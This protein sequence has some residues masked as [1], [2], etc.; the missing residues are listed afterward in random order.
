MRSGLRAI[1]LVSAFAAL[2]LFAFGQTATSSLHGTISDPKGAVVSGA[3]VT[4]TN[5]ATGFRRST[6]SDSQGSYQFLEMP[7]AKYDLLV[8]S[9]GFGPMKQNGIELLVA[10]PATL[11]I[12]MEVSGGIVTVEVT[13]TTPLVNTQDASLGHAFEASQ[14][15]DLPFEGR[16]PAGILSLQTGVVFT[17]NSTHIAGSADSRAGSVNGARSDQTNIT[18]DGVDNNDQLLGTAFQGAIRAPLD[19]LEELKVTTSNSDADSGRSSGGQVS[20]VT[21]SGTNHFHGSFYIYNRPT[22]AAANDWF[23]KAAQLGAGEPNEAPFLLRNTFGVNVGGPI[24]KDRLF[25]FAAYEGQRKR[26]NLQVTRVIPSAG[27]K[28]GSISYP[29]T[30]DP[31]CPASGVETLNAAQIATM[32]PVCST[33]TP[34]TCPLGPGPNPL[35][36]NIGGANPNALFTQYPNANTNTVGDG[37]DYVGYT[38]SSPLPTGLNAY[39]AK[40]DYNLTRDGNHRVFVRGIMNN[41]RQAE[42]N[43]STSITNDGGEQFPGSSEGQVEHDNNKGFTVGYTATFS[44]T[45]INNFRFGYSSELLNLA[46]LQTQPFVHFRGMDDINSFTPTINTHIPVKNIVDDVTKVMGSHTFQFGANYRQVDNLRESNAQNF[47]TAETNVFWTN[48]SGI[49]NTGSSLDPAA[50]NPATNQE[51]FPA[52]DPNFSASYDFAMA[53]LVG[54]IPQVTANYELTK[55]LSLIQQGQLVPR[56]FRDHEIEFYAQDQWRIKPNLT[57]TYGLR[58]SL[59]QP[60]YETTGTQVAPT[61]SFNNYFNQRSIAAY[62]GQVYDPTVGFALDGQANGKAPYWAWDYKDFAP[63]VAFAYSPKGDSGWGRRLWGGQGKTSIRAGYGI[64]FDHFGEGITNTFDRN[65]SFGLTTSEVNPAGI[66]SVDGSARYSGLFNIPTSSND[67]CA[68]PPCSLVGAPPTGPFPVVPPIGATT[69]GGFAITWGLDDKLKTPYSHV[70]DFS[71][72]RELPSNFVFEASYVGRFAH[73]LLQEE[74]L[75]EPTNLRDPA[76]KTTYFQAAQGLARQYSAGTAIQNV[77]TSTVGTNY[78]Q[79]VFPAAAGQAQNVLLD[80][81]IKTGPS[82]GLIQPCG[83]NS[84]LVSPTQQL[85]A[86]QAM[87]DLFC[88]F[89][90]NETTALELADAPGLIN[91]TGDPATGGC[92]PACATIGG[93]LTQGYDYYSPQFSSLFAW[94]SIGNS[95]YNAGQFSLR[96]RSGGMEFDLNY[97]YSKSIDQGS[98]AERVNEFEGFGF[99]SQIINSWFP[100]QNR[101]VS[102][103]DTTHIVNANWVYQLPFGRGKR[104]GSGMGKFANAVLGGWTVSGLW[105][106]SSGYPFSLF[107]PEWSTNFQLQTPAVPVS[108]ARPKT[109]SFIV[110][111][112]GGGTGPNVFQDPGITDS[113]TNPNAAIN[114]FRAAFPGEAG[115]RNGLRGPGTFN[116][117]T[118]VAKTWTITESQFIK[119]S[120]QMFNMT[121]SARFDVGTMS[122]NGNT[123]LS[124]SSSFG[125][126]SST[127]SNPRVSEFSLRYTF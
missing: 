120:W 31:T 57:F 96:H 66:Q 107:S 22:F 30:Q 84:A 16:D 104:F 33:N 95:A 113:S 119:F 69:P 83:T 60:P 67:G 4:I 123:S 40:L 94:R 3:T 127:L 59:L 52:V 43:I 74:D 26:E 97:T 106:W 105:R 8:E 126:F 117:D 121:N 72:T 50:I 1:T 89:A 122:I 19:S 112:A 108:A 11:N 41:D 115:L 55:N 53:A 100:Q 93:N 48:N 47:F 103:F 64:Y 114:L 12:T 63:R 62:N 45:L 80:P 79:N 81:I 61:L 87:Y 118:G 37:F 99:G 82:A 49:S 75:T 78:W 17:G 101:G 51:F 6:K 73:R 54:L 92:F 14:I 124:S 21:K 70:I 116:I 98:N 90:G 35:L 24:I 68:T 125:N 36:A 29:C 2:N 85:T 110:A 77:N 56:H 15:A 18:L 34:P 58:Y 38:F 76:S 109:G 44:P 25:F 27:M 13:G 10:S 5:P 28:I 86:T 71:I 65:G 111:Q 102:D 32:D 9:S 20:L 88:N 46:G 39:V 42:R 7:P 23:N 91:A